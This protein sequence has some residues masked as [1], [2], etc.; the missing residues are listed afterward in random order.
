MALVDIV[1][2]NFFPTQI[3][4]DKKEYSARDVAQALNLARQKAHTSR[5]LHLTNTA[6]YWLVVFTLH[7]KIKLGYL[8]PIIFFGRLLIS[9]V[10]VQTQKTTVPVRASYGIAMTELNK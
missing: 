8:E 2:L 6:E 7:L 9:I 5:K 1:G 4:A 3:L 10:Q